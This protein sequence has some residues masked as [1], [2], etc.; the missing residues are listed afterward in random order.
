MRERLTVR[1]KE[2]IKVIDRVRPQDLAIPY[3]KYLPY[4]GY[5]GDVPLMPAWGDGYRVNVVGL[6]HHPDGNVTKYS[7]EMHLACVERIF[8]KIENHADEI[9]QVEGS[10]LEG[11]RNL[12]VAYGTTVRSASEA[13]EELRAKGRTDLGFLRLKTLWPF[14]ENKIRSLVGQ[15]K[16]VFFPEMN[17][18]FMLHPLKEALRDRVQQFIPVPCLGQLHAPDQIIGKIEEVLGK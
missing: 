12:V 10:F 2:E 1:S 17:L 15:L 18:G 16:N 5:E 13:V 7:P 9:A 6:V 11:C 8:R 4:E 3:E 14:P